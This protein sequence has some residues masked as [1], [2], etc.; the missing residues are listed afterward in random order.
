VTLASTT[1]TPEGRSIRTRIR[2]T[3]GV[4]LVVALVAGWLARNAT[5]EIVTGPNGSL[6]VTDLN[7]TAALGELLTER[8]V[9]VSPAVTRLTDLDGFAAVLV[10]DPKPGIPYFEE[11]IIA[12][13]QFLDSGGTIIV[14][15]PIHPD[16]VGSVLPADIG[17][18]YSAQLDGAI[19][20]PL[21]GVG[22][23]VET[24]GIRNVA[25][26]EAF[27]PMVGEPPIVVAFPRG[28]GVVI[29]SSDGSIFHNRRI[30]D[31]AP[32]AVGVIGTGPLLADEVR[33]GFETRPAS[34]DPLGLLGS[35]PP[36]AR[37]TVLLLLAATALSLVAYS[38]RWAPVERHHRELK[39][40][41][42][43]LVEAVGGLLLRTDQ[44][45]EA[46]LP[47]TERVETLVRRSLR[48]PA[49]SVVDSAVAAAKLG[50]APD[51]LERALRPQ[52]DDD[53]ITAHRVL[54]E[55]HE[56]MTT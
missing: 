26:S 1:I 31:N 20:Y 4:L 35:L 43:E 34:E 11:E 8:G 47:L 27:L 30:D 21:G 39:P 3:V 54:T 6:F 29:Y 25:T 5:S 17:F 16:L 45:V 53:L 49:G 13:T 37:R 10:F 2:L 46:A 50:L 38:R 9:P 42:L 7:G 15:G 22:G 12:L 14:T 33:H 19:R 52:T 44:P 41:R 51:D 55:M 18:D 24:A 56:R 36:A 48:L 28:E 23:I 40:A 32:W